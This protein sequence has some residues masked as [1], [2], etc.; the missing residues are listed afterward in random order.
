[1][2]IHFKLSAHIYMKQIATE[3]NGHR[4]NSI[5]QHFLH[6]LCHFS[7]FFSKQRATVQNLSIKS[8]REAVRS[9]TLGQG[10]E[11]INEFSFSKAR[12]AFGVCFH[13]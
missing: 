5:F 8:K 9:Q 1:M 7:T 2:K 3:G 13:M 11:L 12:P 6:D 4:K 10:V